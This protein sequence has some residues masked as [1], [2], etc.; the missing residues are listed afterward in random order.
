MS[1]SDSWGGPGRE[2]NPANTVRFWL[3][4]GPAASSWRFTWNTE[5]K[6]HSNYTDS[7]ES[8]STYWYWMI[9]LDSFVCLSLSWCDWVA[10]SFMKL[11]CMKNG[12]TCTIND[13]KD[14]EQ[15]WR[16]QKE[17]LVWSRR[18][19]YRVSSR[20]EVPVCP[21]DSCSNKN[22]KSSWRP[23][24]SYLHPVHLTALKIDP[25]S[26]SQSINNSLLMHAQSSR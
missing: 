1:N 18:L 21:R 26:I 8:M 13:M 2:I 7:N 24:A 25:P 22:N 17:V 9:I 19:C 5:F 6:K 15:T 20:S 3:V 12:F 11:K 14:E 10:G 23:G 4:F 16:V